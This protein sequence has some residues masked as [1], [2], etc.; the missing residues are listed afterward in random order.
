MEEIL[1]INPDRKN[2]SKTF[3]NVKRKRKK[4]KKKTFTIHDG[5]NYG[6]DNY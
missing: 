4:R 2:T 3:I 6:R 5:G 1:I